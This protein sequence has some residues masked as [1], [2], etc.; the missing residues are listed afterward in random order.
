MALATKF[1]S[2]LQKYIAKRGEY[3]GHI[4]VERFKDAWRNNYDPL[5]LMIQNV[6]TANLTKEQKEK[7]KAE[8]M[9]NLTDDQLVEFRKK[10]ENLKRLE[11]GD[12]Q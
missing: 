6:N 10:Q 5:L 4:N 12:Y 7:K 1:D 3:N 8:I 9:S 2:G 11:K